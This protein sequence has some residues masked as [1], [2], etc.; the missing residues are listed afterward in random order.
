M[1]RLTLLHGVVAFAFNTAILALMINVGASL[2]HW[3]VHARSL[4]ALDVVVLI[5]FVALCLGVGALGAAV[6]ATSVNDWY[7]GLGKPSFTPPNAVFGPVWTVLYILM[8]VAAWRVWRSGDRRHGAGPA[9]A[10]CPP[11]GPQSGLE[12]GVLRPA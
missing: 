9:D 3:R 7:A 2:V 5:L 11:A 12:R 10:V 1:R 6:T 4:P 8:A